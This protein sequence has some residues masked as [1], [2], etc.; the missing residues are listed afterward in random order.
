[1][2]CGNERTASNETT[3]SSVSF[4]SLSDDLDDMDLGCDDGWPDCQDD[5]QDAVGRPLYSLCHASTVDIPDMSQGECC[6]GDAGVPGPGSPH[7]DALGAHECLVLETGHLPPRAARRDILDTRAFPGKEGHSRVKDVRVGTCGR[8][9]GTAAPL[10]VT[11]PTVPP[12]SH[13]APVGA[14]AWPPAMPT[15]GPSTISSIP[16]T[17][18]STQPGITFNRTRLSGGT[19]PSLLLPEPSDM[20]LLPMASDDVLTFM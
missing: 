10:T 4:F 2:F 7:W 20:L 6:A 14:A 1:M 12:V 17:I 11:G 8:C 16:T 18:A 3:A 15:L 5:T 9:P 19:H 13:H